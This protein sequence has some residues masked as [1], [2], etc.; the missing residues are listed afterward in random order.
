MK[1]RTKVLIFVLCFA[2]SAETF[3]K[4][5]SYS[6]VCKGMGYDLKP[7]TLSFSS[8]FDP[9]FAQRPSLQGATTFRLV[10]DQDSVVL[11]DADS[12]NQDWYRQIE[13]GF[14]F[15]GRYKAIKFSSD[16]QNVFVQVAYR[17]GLGL[18]G[19]LT[20]LSS[21]V[22]APQDMQKKDVAFQVFAE[23]DVATTLSAAFKCDFVLQ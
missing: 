5:I 19:D 18:L 6:A 13:P 14:N 16:H 23:E 8:S 4:N 11:L 12:K 7:L 9:N 20:Q 22:F 3:A 15:L 10:R 17:D 2:F 1:T 21:G